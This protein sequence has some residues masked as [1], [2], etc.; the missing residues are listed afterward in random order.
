M[1]PQSSVGLGETSLQA[2]EAEKATFYAPLEA[3]ATPAPTSTCPDERE[4][5]VDFGA[6]MHMLSQK[7]L[8]SEELETL[9]RSRNPTVVVTANGEVQTHEEAQV[10]VH[11]LGL[12]V[13]VQL[14]E[15]T[16]AVLS[17]GQLCEEHGYSCEWVSGQ[18][19]SGKSIIWKTDNFVPLVVPRLSTNPESGSSG[20]SLSQDSLRREA[21]QARKELVQPALSSSSSKYQSEVTNW[22]SGDWCN[23]QKSKIKIKRGMT[24]R[25]RKTRWQ[26]F[27]AG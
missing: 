13:T 6:S 27:L 20:A 21:E 5:V 17:L 12:F 7:G 2:Q 11:D 19:P 24:R 9:R 22:P 3:R 8:S 1:R 15:V 14:L 26:I 16:A 4:F 23:P 18:T 10:C 25:I